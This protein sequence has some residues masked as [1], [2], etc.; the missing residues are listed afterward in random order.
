MARLLM[1]RLR[2][3]KFGIISC[4]AG[5]PTPRGGFRPIADIRPSANTLPVVWRI[6]VLL[7]ISGALIIGASACV[8]GS[9]PDLPQQIAAKCETPVSWVEIGPDGTPS[10]QPPYGADYKKVDCILG[11]LRPDLTGINF[12]GNE[13]PGYGISARQ[14]ADAVL[15]KAHDTIFEKSGYV[16]HSAN[17]GESVQFGVPDTDDRAFRVDC[18]NNQLLVIAPANTNASEGTAR[19]AI[20]PNGEQRTAVISYL[21]DGP[22]FVVTI[23]PNDPVIAQILMPGRIRIHTPDSVVSVPNEGGLGLLR[24]LVQRCRG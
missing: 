13:A 22:N 15:E 4:G 7:C 14:S 8:H 10:V 3:L 18:D 12:I 6:P 5:A 19:V 24:S 16:W 17:G 21:G 1:S 2:I 20:F 11:E 9:Q 23:A